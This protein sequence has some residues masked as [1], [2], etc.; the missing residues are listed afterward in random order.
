MSQ[1]PNLVW[2]PVSVTREQRESLNGHGAVVVWLTGLSGAGKST[3]AHAVEKELHR[4]GKRTIV[5][6]GDN[7]RHGLCSNLGFSPEDRTENLRRIAEV[8]RLL[9]EAGVI[10]L[11]AFISPMR[12]HRAMI[13]SIIG[14]ENFI[15]V[16]VQC[17]L[18]ICESRDVKGVYQRARAGEIKDFTG[19]SAPYEAP[20]VPDLVVAT[21]SMKLEE[22]VEQLLGLINRPG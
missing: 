12:E 3:L 5:L 14:P 17:P 13:R 4:Q 22:C 9:V 18:E 10:T 11:A 20:E 2:H 1:I 15:E 21:E 16:Y 8:A 6:D 7:V 19:I